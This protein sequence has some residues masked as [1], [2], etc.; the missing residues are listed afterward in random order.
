MNFV[1]GFEYGFPLF[2]LAGLDGLIDDAGC[3]GFSGSD[4]FFRYTF[5]I[6]EANDY[7]HNEAHDTDNNRY[8]DVSHCFGVSS[9]NYVL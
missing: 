5:A 8:D 4:F 2:G 3:F 7:A 1:L 6:L 9:L